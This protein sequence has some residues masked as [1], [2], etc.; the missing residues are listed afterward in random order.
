MGDLSKAVE[1]IPAYIAR[2]ASRWHVGMIL[3]FVP[4]RGIREPVPKPKGEPVHTH[5]LAGFKVPP[6]PSSSCFARWWRT[7]VS[8]LSSRQR[9]GHLGVAP[10][11]F[12]VY[13]VYRIYGFRV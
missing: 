5:V 3:H 2:C 10:I 12:M 13:R 9:V 11:P 1:S 6:R 7:P 8:P 4:Y